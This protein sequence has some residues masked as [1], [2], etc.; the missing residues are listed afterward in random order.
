M[1]I[2]TKFNLLDSVYYMSDNKIRKGNIYA[3]YYKK[4]Y[5]TKGSK[6]TVVEITYGV[7]ESVYED[8]KSINEDMIFSTKEEL[9]NS[10]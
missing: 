6:D 1:D 7:S 9:F 8:Y 10:I 4:S 2:K 3:I 5:K